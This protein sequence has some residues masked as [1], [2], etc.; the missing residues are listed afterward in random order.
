MLKIL[1]K[2]ALVSVLVAVLCDAQTTLERPA[3]PAK[4]K[5]S[6]PLPFKIGET[7]DYEL[8]FSKLIFSGAIGQLKFTAAKTTDEQKN[9]LIQLN[10]EADSKGFFPKLFGIKVRDRFT[11]TVSADDFGLAAA[12]RRLEEGKSK[13]E[14]RIFINRESG[15][16]TYMERDLAN[17]SAQAKVKEA[18]SPAWVQDILSAIYFVRTQDLKEGGVIP[19]PISDA[20]SVYNVEVIVGPRE[21]V[22]VNAGKFKAVQLDAKIFGGRFIRR[23]GELLIWV[24]DDLRRIPVKARIK[25]SGFTVNVELKKMPKD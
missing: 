14:Q 2:A 25:V 20:G 19:V 13:R 12:N 8:S 10:V 4:P 16:V 22:K 23:N 21:E 5:I 1:L 9:E 24:T 6:Q 7:L 18:A 15:R 11:A 3:E 17:T